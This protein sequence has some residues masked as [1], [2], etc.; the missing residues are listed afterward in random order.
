MIVWRI[1]GKVISTQA[2]SQ[3]FY[4][5]GGTTMEGP[6]VPSEERSAGAPRGWSLGRGA[7]PQP[8]PVWGSGT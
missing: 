7:A 3:D 4:K 6:K 1:R 5:G 8:L 2:R